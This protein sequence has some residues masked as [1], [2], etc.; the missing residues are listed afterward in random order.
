MRDDT[1][2]GRDVCIPL[3]E[4][5]EVEDEELVVADEAGEEVHEQQLHLESGPRE[6]GMRAHSVSLSTSRARTVASSVVWRLISIRS[7]YGCPSHLSVHVLSLLNSL[8]A[9]P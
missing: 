2:L 4:A 3:D 1:G 6:R 9:R 7:C 5:V 8:S